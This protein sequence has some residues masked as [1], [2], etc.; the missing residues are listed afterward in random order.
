MIDMNF[1]GVLNEVLAATSDVDP[2]TFEASCKENFV[3][4]LVFKCYFIAIIV[5]VAEFIL[6]W[7]AFEDGGK[8]FNQFREFL[9]VSGLY[10]VYFFAKDEFEDHREL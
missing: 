3:I 8:D 5:P 9:L 10:N 1:V 4:V 2:H 6:R 7:E